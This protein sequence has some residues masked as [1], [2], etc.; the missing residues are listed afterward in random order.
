M[1]HKASRWIPLTVLVV[2]GGVFVAV[3]LGASAQKG[4]L[5]GKNVGVIICTNQNPFCAA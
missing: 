2:L 1:R 5:S 4:S 3:A